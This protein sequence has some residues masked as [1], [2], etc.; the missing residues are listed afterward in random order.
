M[1]ARVQLIF[2]LPAR[3]IVWTS[4]MIKV[5]SEE[6]AEIKWIDKTSLTSLKLFD[7]SLSA[8]RVY[9]SNHNI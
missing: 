8:L 7:N 3:R 4:Q 2:S 1:S 5:P 9:F 6:V